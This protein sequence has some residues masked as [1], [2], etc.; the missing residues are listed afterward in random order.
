MKKDLFDVTFL[1]PIRI[2]SIIRLENLILTTK[3]LLQHFNCHIIVLEASPYNNG[4][5]KRLLNKKIKYYFVEDFDSVFYRTK[6]INLMT[7]KVETTFLCIWDADVI[8]SPNQILKA[9]EKLRYE[10]YDAAIP[11]DGRA[12]DT[13]TIVREYFVKHRSSRFLSTQIMKMK[14]LHENI[15]LRGGAIFVNTEAYKKAGME[16]TD[17]YGWGAEDFERYERWITLGYKIY[18]VKGVLF[19]LSHP[20]GDNSRYNTFGQLINSEEALFKTKVSSLKEL[21]VE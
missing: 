2:D 19:H 8:V 5:I 6:Y 4:F 9:M 14:A 13:S 18:I 11:Y 3:F 1:I 15:A 12:L 7:E 10:D 17:F 16:N 21:I 20:R